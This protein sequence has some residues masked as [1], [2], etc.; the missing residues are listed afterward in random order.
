MMAVLKFVCDSTKIPHMLSD[1]E[2]EMFDR[3]GK[4]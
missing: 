4:D 1:A 3:I 2:N